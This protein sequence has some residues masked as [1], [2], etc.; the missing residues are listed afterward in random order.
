MV[1]RAAAQVPVRAV[2]ASQ[3]TPAALAP[4]SSV[5]AVAVARA[6]APG[7]RRW[8]AR[9]VEAARP[10]LRTANRA[11]RPRRDCHQEAYPA[12]AVEVAA[13]TATVPARLLSPTAH[14]C[15]AAMAATEASSSFRLL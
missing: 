2:P 15:A 6:A 1:A 3:A 5:A 11:S 7:A 14:P 12:A 4:P 10:S 8:P 9:A 13:G